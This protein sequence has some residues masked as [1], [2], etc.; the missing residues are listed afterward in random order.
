MTF[1]YLWK[2]GQTTWEE[3]KTGYAEG[4]S[5]WQKPSK[6]LIWPSLLKIIKSILANRLTTGGM[7]RRISHSY[8]TLQGTLSQRIMKRLRFS[9]PSLLLSYYPARYPQGTEPPKLVYRDEEQNKPPPQLLRRKQ[10]P[11]SPPALTQIYRPRWD[12]PKCT[13]RAGRSDC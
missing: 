10:R 7:P 12:Q 13:D 2:K 9:T 11:A 8:W 1:Y 3:F 5:E 6:N 4:K